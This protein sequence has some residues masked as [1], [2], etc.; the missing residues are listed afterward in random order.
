MRPAVES[1]RELDVKRFLERIYR[2]CP[3]VLQDLVVS[4]EGFRIERARYSAAFW[5]QYAEALRR[6]RL[7]PSAVAEYRDSKIRDLVEGAVA[8]TI[9]YKEL[10][11]KLGLKAADIRNAN[12]LSV[13]PILS[14]EFVRGNPDLFVSALVDKKDTVTCSTSGTTGSGL[15]FPAT[16]A[17]VRE[18][19]AIWWRFRNLHGIRYGTWCGYFGG[20]LIVPATEK[21]APFWRVNRPGRQ[22]IFSSYHLSESTVDAYVDEIERR[23]IPW[24]HGYPSSLAL[25]AAMVLDR[26]RRVTTVSHVSIGSENLNEHQSSMIEQAFG[27][28]PIQHYGMAEGV[29]NF[30]ECANGHLHLDED[31]A[32]AEFIPQV[33]GDGF[34]IIG[35]NFSNPAFPL[36]RYDVGDIAIAPIEIECSGSRMLRVVSKIDGRADDYLVAK[37][38]T[39]IG[40]LGPIFKDMTSIRESQFTQTT[41][42]QALLRV[43]KR[44]GYSAAD[45]RKLN[46]LLFERLGGGVDV[47]IEYVS[48][49][50][51]TK[52]GKLR[53]VVNRIAE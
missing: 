39:R 5:S 41:V 53:L 45:E 32:F 23:E 30:S 28:R 17:A 13:L 10:F 12:D 35:T 22:V 36:L 37:D 4:V 14:K 21:S 6:A 16:K 50:Q 15:V 24:L 25:L 19:W 7:E 42:G 31:Y 11:K 33:D 47:A 9:Y 43:V 3:V 38:G 18:Q 20:R 51:K 52:S 2:R 49:I 40:R 8:G 26:G 29:A 27:V 48:E 46:E 34:R 44:A 1:S